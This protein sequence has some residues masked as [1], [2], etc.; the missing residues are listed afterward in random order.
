MRVKHCWVSPV[1]NHQ[2]PLAGFVGDK[3]VIQ[4]A[5]VHNYVEQDKTF[6]TVAGA[7]GV[8]SARNEQEAIYAMAWAKN[9]WADTLG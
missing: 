6:K 8:S 7:G 5:S 9:I 1:L 2:W 4:V 3:E